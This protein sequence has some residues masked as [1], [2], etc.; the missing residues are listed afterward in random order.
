MRYL[1]VAIPF[2]AM[3][4]ALGWERLREG[5]PRIRWL[6]T[7]AL[8]VAVPLGLERTL[9]VLRG[10]SQAA[11]DVARA[12]ARLDPAPRV[13]VLEQ[14]WAY[15]E[16]LY[17]G[18]G[19]LLR[20]LPPRLPLDGESVE[21][22]ARGADAVALYRDDVNAGVRRVLADGGMRPCTVVA[23]GRSAAVV[24]YLPTARPCPA[25]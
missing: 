13:V 3:A 14:M 8:L 9:H 4:A 22:A 18:K 17:L 7:A 10:K 21:A 6:A 16:R 11:V 20:D 23:R 2:L 24:L 5:P 1:Q 12:L 15:G 19:V 25:I